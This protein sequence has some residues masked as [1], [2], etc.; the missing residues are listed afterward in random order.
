M[1]HVKCYFHFSRIIFRAAL[2][3]EKGRTRSFI[4][5]ATCVSLSY[6]LARLTLNTRKSPIPGASVTVLRFD[7][8]GVSLVARRIV[9][10][11]A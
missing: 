10:L 3:G 9:T 4:V 8:L 6:S 2:L 11:D 1:G 7:V 5:R